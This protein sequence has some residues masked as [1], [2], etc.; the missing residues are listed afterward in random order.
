MNTELTT[1]LASEIQR[2]HL[3]AQEL[4]T[5]AQDNAERAIAAAVECG[6]YIKDAREIH[7]GR[8]L[9]WLRD[10][11]PGLTGEQ[12]K[13]YLSIANLHKDR[14]CHALEAHQLRLL[15]IMPHP[16]REGQQSHVVDASKWI[17]YVGKVYSGLKRIEEF[18]PL[19]Q[20]GQEEKDVALAHLEPINEIYKRLGGI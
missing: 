18:K 8:L 2:T 13:A 1:E 11:I 10:T 6:N 3:I 19:D 9:A 17:S 20:W 15:G 7:K 14:E 12:A 5:S 4:A 16:E